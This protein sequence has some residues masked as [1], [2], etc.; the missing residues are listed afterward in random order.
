MGWEC[1]LLIEFNGTPWHPR[2]VSEDM[3]VS[4]AGHTRRLMPSAKP[5]PKNVF[6]LSHSSYGFK[7]YFEH[8][9]KYRTDELAYEAYEKDLIKKEVAEK[10]GFQFY[11]VW[12]HTKYSS[13]IHELTDICK[14]TI[15]KKVSRQSPTIKRRK[16]RNSGDNR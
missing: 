9:H 15:A 12:T 4:I 14:H 3:L 11:E 16:K 6:S 8:P 2:P 5:L 13:Q 1:K 10:E 7:Y